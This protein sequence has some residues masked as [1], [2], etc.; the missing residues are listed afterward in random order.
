MKKALK[1][2]LMGGALAA[3]VLGAAPAAQAAP[4]APATIQASWTCS[5]T[6]YSNGVVYSP[7][8]VHSGAIKAYL[9]C[10]DGYR[11]IVPG[12]ST[13]LGPG[14]WNITLVCPSGSVRV[15]RGFYSIN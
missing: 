1:T 5:T 10:S 8:T 2:V 7:C 15:G 6:L 11:Y 12:G 4:A 9:D 13:W 3:S 14:S